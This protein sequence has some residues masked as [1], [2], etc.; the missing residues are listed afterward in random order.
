MKNQSN[1]GI[2]QII[3]RISFAAAIVLCTVLCFVLCGCDV[4]NLS[5]LSEFSKAYTGEYDCTHASLAGEDLL[6]EYAHVKL[7][8]DKGGVFRLTAQKK[9]GTMQS[10][11]GRYDYDE[12]SGEITFSANLFGRKLDKTCKMQNG[13]FTIC[14]SLRGKELV[15]K[16]EV[17]G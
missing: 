7:A 8:L 4:E 5:S 2:I 13:S 10:V 14:Q 3:R 15:L 9:R 16:F 17:A 6:E 12:E 1:F 11:Y